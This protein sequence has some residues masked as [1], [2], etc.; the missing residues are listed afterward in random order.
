MPGPAITHPHQLQRRGSAAKV[1]SL[2]FYPL[3][4]MVADADHLTLQ[5]QGLVPVSAIMSTGWT[6]G[7]TAATAYSRMAATSK[8]LASTFAGTAQPNSGPDNAIGDCFRSP[9]ALWGRAT[10]TVGW[11]LSFGVKASS[12]SGATGGITYRIWKSTDPTGLT[13]LTELTSGIQTTT[14]VS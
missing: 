1:F 9:H 11:T 6:V 13:G 12:A 5:Q 2:T 8:R 14:L 7:T 10:A 3:D 4:H